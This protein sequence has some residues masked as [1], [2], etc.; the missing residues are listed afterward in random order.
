MNKRFKNYF[1]LSVLSGILFFAGWPPSPFPFTLFLAFVPLL[2]I[3]ADLKSTS[4]SKSGWK[5]FG[6]SYLAFLIWNGFTTWWVWNA[7]PAGA[8]FM[9]LANSLL[10]SIPMILYYHTL[11]KGG[12]V[13][14]YV[15]LCL[16]WISFEYI[17]LN[18]DLSWPWLTLGNG[19]ASAH[20]LVQ[21]YEITG[22]LGGTLWVL[23]LNL[24]I[25]KGFLLI[26]NCQLF[27][28]YVFGT[29]FLFT[30]P[31]LVSL[32]MYLNYHEKGTDQQIVVLQP[33]VDPYSG[34]FIGSEKLL[35]LKEK[36]DQFIKIS[37]SELTDSTRFL[38]WPETAI[39][40]LYNEESLLQYPVFLQVV[41][42]T[43][44]YPQ[45]SLLSGLSSY[46]QYGN[47]PASATA[48]FSENVGYYDVFNSAVF[49]NGN[50]LGSIYRKS[51]LVPGIESFPYPQIL[52]FL[53]SLVKSFGGTTAGLGKQK[54]RTVLYNN[55][56]T[57]VAPAICYE[58]IY[59]GFMSQYIRNGANLIFIIT[60]DAWWGDTA[61]Y[62]QHQAYAKLRA[63]ETRRSI[64][65]SANTGISSFINQ[66]GEV[67]ESAAYGTQQ[68]IK[69]KLKANH[70][71][72]FY[73]RYGDYLGRTAS[74]LSV[75]LLLIVF[76]KHKIKK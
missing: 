43:E 30:A 56:G 37:E 20:W 40:D 4:Y 58:S 62:K 22:I 74:W 66:R 2:L 53:S 6:W 34:K 24:L 16:Y 28:R 46:Q 45:L 5:F 19:F 72:T 27:T 64:A 41:N 60:N 55:E 67:T 18:W 65:R 9:I 15:G 42:L 23:V 51:R 25:F 35:P 38:I 11:K 33:N 17:H 75:F 73:A 31:L 47:L 44:K 49:L 1:L 71:L 10:M 63:I 3:A 14:G 26:K 12:T 57:G 69:S 13:A 70:E 32:S 59:G 39:D 7:T 50:N 61:G 68:V 29:V 52:G 48:R 54:E 36:I 8:I 76:V 21:W